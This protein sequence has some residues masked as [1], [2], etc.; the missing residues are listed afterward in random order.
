VTTTMDIEIWPRGVRYGSPEFEFKGVVSPRIQ[1]MNN[2]DHGDGYIIGGRLTDEEGRAVSDWEHDNAWSIR[3]EMFCTRITIPWFGLTEISGVVD[4]LQAWDLPTNEPREGGQW[5]GKELCT[6]EFCQPHYTVE[7]YC[8]PKVLRA[9]GRF[10]K[11]TLRER[12][13]EAES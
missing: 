3:M 9:S 2:R 13:R 7:H 4:E 12:D 10:V 1:I 6:S 8:P 5:H 11:V